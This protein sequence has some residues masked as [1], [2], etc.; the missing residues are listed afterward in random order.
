MFEKRLRSIVVVCLLAIM[1]LSAG[2]VI[3]PTASAL[4]WTQD[5]D[6]E[7]SQGALTN[8]EIV[9]TGP[10]AYVA[11]V[12][13]I[14]NW[15][16]L[17]PAVE[18][19]AR[20]GPV[21]AYD[22]T[23]DVMIMFGG[24]DGSNLDDTWEY[25][26]ATNSWTL[27]TTTGAP[28]IRVW[29][30]LAYD[31]VNDVFVLFGG[32]G[33]GPLT[34]TWEYDPGTQT[35][36]ETTPGFSPGTMV[37]YNLVYDSSAGR[38]ILGA[39]GFLS[40]LFETW[41]YDASLDSWTMMSPA[42]DP[43]TRGSHSF[44]YMPSIGRSVLFGGVDGFIYLSDVWEYDYSSD[45]WQQ[46]S[47]G[48]GPTARF[49]HA[50]AYRTFDL[51]VV[52]YGGSEDGGGYPTDTWKYEYIMGSE[53]WTQVMTI[54][55]PGPRTSLT[56]TY[57]PT[58]NGTVVFGGDNGFTRVNDTWEL[59]GYYTSMGLFT[60]SYFDSLY[61]DTEYT[62]IWWNLTPAAQPPNTNMNFQIAVSNNSAG[63]WSFAGPDGTGGTYYTVPGQQLWAG[64]VGRYFKYT[65]TL[66]SFDG[67][68]TP[69]LDDVTIVYTTPTLDPK[70]VETYPKNFDGLTYIGIWE[71]MTVWFS[72]PMAVGT[73]SWSILPNPGG[74]TEDWDTENTI[75]Y[76]NHSSPFVEKTLHTVTVAIDDLGGNPLISGPVP[77]PWVFVTVAIPPY[78]D[79][80]EPADSEIDIALD[81]PIWINF[82][83][84][85]DT[86]TV[87]WNILP[88]PGGWTEQW[89]NGDQ[90]LY[91]THSTDYSQCV[92][93]TVQVTAGDDLKGTGLIPGPAPNPW[94]FDTVC[95]DPFVM[96]TDPGDGQ[97]NVALD[98]PLT[99]DFSKEVDSTTFL[100][101]IA[102]NPGGWTDF[103]APQ[104]LSVVLDH[105]TLFTDCTL[106]T[107]EVLA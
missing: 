96:S 42:S 29:S 5:D 39:Q 87:L 88:D 26:Y 10:G 27:L 31:S 44:T 38:A 69:R 20:E 2:L 56:I 106:Y 79:E 47:L 49:G 15:G 65:A 101:T 36:T 43:G 74:W 100:W 92:Q 19:S 55:N 16:D 60:S 33:P 52:V 18:P 57:D 102:P 66:I 8:T 3:M 37:S 64:T 94:R 89:Q 93:Y 9:G 82:S 90:T 80:T 97:I 45:S 12:M 4:T 103:W 53:T 72:E 13:G 99:I 22:S 54:S 77:N 32:Y 24:Y 30:S 105:S 78:I 68:N 14:E 17:N 67:K 23:R 58:E 51:S 25:D 59:A 7:F 73:L 75:L 98:Y 70:I 85:M 41:S 107:V 91:L 76:L 81:Y 95:L 83:E 46:M 34:D 84:P 104:N 40:G 86:A 50:A 61:T 21:M 71:N 11:L 1:M 35:W 62:S 28:P 48:S 63:P 6:T